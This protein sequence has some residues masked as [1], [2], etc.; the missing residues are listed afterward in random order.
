MSGRLTGRGVL[1]VGATSGMGRA[2]ALAFGR[3]GA[4]VVAAARREDLLHE[5]CG[6]IAAESGSPALGVPCDVRNRA[7]VASLVSGAA[8]FLGRIDCVV[9]ATGTNLPEREIARLAPGNWE[10]MLAVNLTGAFHCTQLVLPHLRAQGGGLLIYIS[11]IA[12]WRPD[13]SGV[14]GVAYTASKC[15]MDGLAYGVRE[16]EKQHRIRTCVLYPG[17]TDTPLVF[18]RPEPPSAAVLGRALQPEDVADACLFVAG[19]PERCHVPSLVL[20]PAEL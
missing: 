7:D 1:I 8:E 3:A 10:E 18:Q 9:Y 4:R 20:Y 12:A 17:L 14:S 2:T 11:S 15:G 13:Q 16:E 19:L 5:L 6:V